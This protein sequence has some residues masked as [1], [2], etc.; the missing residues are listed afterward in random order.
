MPLKIR[1]DS[2]RERSEQVADDFKYPDPIQGGDEPVYRQRGIT[3][4]DNAAREREETARFLPEIIQPGGP[5]AMVVTRQTGIIAQAGPSGVLMADHLAG[6]ADSPLLTD[7]PIDCSVDAG[8][9]GY[10]GVVPGVPAAAA[11]PVVDVVRS[12]DGGSDPRD[13]SG[14]PQVFSADKLPVIK[15]A[16]VVP[17]VLSDQAAPRVT[18]VRF[19][20]YREAA[21]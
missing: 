17:V 16:P 4:E 8:F 15:K 3:P 11:Q 5:D 20:G 12:D 1:S 13:A 6:G 9:G 7:R 14:G 21:T 2:N 18:R 19:Q 10:P